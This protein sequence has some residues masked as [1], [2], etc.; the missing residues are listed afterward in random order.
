MQP[1]VFL[2]RDGTIIKEKEY[3]HNPDEVELLPGAGLALA[4]LQR[5][6]FILIVVTN[7][8]GIGRGYYTETEMHAVNDRLRQLLANNGI[9]LDARQIYFCP[10][11]PDEN[12]ACRKPATAM[13]EQAAKDWNIDLPRSFVIGDKLADVELGA[14]LN[15]PAILVQTGYGARET[16]C[17]ADKAAYIAANL[18]DAAGWII[19][20]KAKT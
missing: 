13:A 6:G 9:K 2:D 5:Q 12:C 11:V 19:K 16:I 7:Q 4:Q 15:L 18:A 14:N 10:H 3:L 1:A 17:A 8:S 20:I